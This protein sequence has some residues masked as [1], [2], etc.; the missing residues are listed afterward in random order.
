MHLGCTQF[1]DSPDNEYPE[2]SR[3]KFFHRRA[4]RINAV[5]CIKLV[6][7]SADAKRLVNRRRWRSP[8]C[9]NVNNV[10]RLS[11]IPTSLND[12]QSK[13]VIASV[14]DSYGRRGLGHLISISYRKNP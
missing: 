14:Y 4:K 10:V 7:V 3:R 6:V 1:F 12:Q 8:P 13:R 2:P 9:G 11:Q 5:V